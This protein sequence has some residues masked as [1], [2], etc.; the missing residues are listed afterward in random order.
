LGVIYDIGRKTWPQIKDILE[1]NYLTE[2][3]LEKYTDT[4]FNFR[5][6]SRETI[7]QW[8]NQVD[9]AAKDLEREVR[10]I[11]SAMTTSECGYYLEGGLEFINKFFRGI[12]VVG[13]K[14]ER[15]KAVARTREGRERF[16]VQSVDA[17]IQREFRSKFRKRK[18]NAVTAIKCFGCGK[19]GHLVR[20]CRSKERYS[21]YDIEGHEGWD[22]W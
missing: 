5:Q 22:K 13:L 9:T 15:V 17:A 11:S 4:L 7:T 6:G 20:T 3:I 8:K 12:L 1:E 21:K 19:P 14:D 18:A 16:I 2:I 10:Q